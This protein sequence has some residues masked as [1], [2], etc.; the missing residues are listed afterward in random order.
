MSLCTSSFF[1]TVGIAQPPA[2]LL[3]EYREF[4]PI[5]NFEERNRGS[6]C[7]SDQAII[8]IYE[9]SLARNTYLEFMTKNIIP[10]LKIFPVKPLSS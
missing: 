2:F 10:R 6:G 7:G 3:S 9:N 5:S 4:K 8:P 1:I